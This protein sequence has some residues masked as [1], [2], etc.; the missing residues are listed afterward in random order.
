MK[1]IHKYEGH[2]SVTKG[3]RI[4]SHK[5]NKFLKLL[6]DR[7]GYLSVSLSK[8]NKVSRASVHRIVAHAYICNDDNKPCVNHIDGD[9]KNNQIGNLEWVTYSENSVHAK[10][11]GLT[12][13]PPTMSGKYGYEHNRS[14]EVHQ[15][16][17]ITGR[18]VRSFG[19]ANTAEKELN[20]G[21]GKI[22]CSI[23]NEGKTRDGFRYSY[24]K[25]N[26]FELIKL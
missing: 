17:A 6:N 1:Y 3:G 12:P 18:Y 15:Y 11:N 14:K 4:F 24:K 22:S 2:Y 20:Y 10:I 23:K 13:P 26:S 21:A 25:E 5:S 8:D 7:N 19:S 9:K 16:C